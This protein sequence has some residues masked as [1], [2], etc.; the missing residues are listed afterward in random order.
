MDVR[1]VCSPLETKGFDTKQLRA[2][3]L[4]E[5]LFAP[6]KISMAYSHLDRTIVGG[7]V[8]LAGAL[9]L[10]SNKQIGSENFLDRREIGIIN[11]GAPGTIEADG[12]SYE[13]APREC[14]YLPMGTVSVT[15]ASANAGAPAEFYFISTPAHHA[16]PAMKITED[17]ANCLEL[18]TSSDANVRILRQ[19]IHPDVCK[20]C[21]LVMGITTILDGSVWNTMPCHTHDRRSEVYL[22]F[23]M[24]EETRVFHFMGEPTETRHL[25]MK[26]KQAVLSP[27]WSIHSGAGTGRYSFI[28][29]MAGDNQ[30]F[31]DMDFVAMKDLR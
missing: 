11:I 31:T 26:E 3:F 9:Q 28:W 20:S 22:Y 30:D 7:V 1:Q 12:T 8:P 5:D 13:L 16:Y 4:V 15:F 19:Y 14:L 18:G 17:D 27:G 29:S 23:D 6:G 2:N 21:Q 10:E 24:T 25:V